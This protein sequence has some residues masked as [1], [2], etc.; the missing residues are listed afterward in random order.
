MDELISKFKVSKGSSLNLKSHYP[1]F[2]GDFISKIIVET[3]KEMNMKLPE[4]PESEKAMLQEC[5]ERLIDEID[6]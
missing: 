3:F 4:L 2:S 6:V 1:R 5:R